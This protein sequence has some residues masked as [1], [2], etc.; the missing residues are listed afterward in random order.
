MQI[1]KKDMRYK[2]FGNGELATRLI[3]TFS[4]IRRGD[5]LYDSLDEETRK[6]IQI[7]VLGGLES[8]ITIM[9]NDEYKRRTISNEQLEKIIW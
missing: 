5:V 6:G 3:K 4:D 9:I 2:Y 1:E 7:N 8:E